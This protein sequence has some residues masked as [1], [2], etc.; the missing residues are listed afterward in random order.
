MQILALEVNSTMC[1]SWHHRLQTVLIAVSVYLIFITFL[2]SVVR[3]TRAHHHHG[4]CC[5]SVAGSVRCVYSEAL[6]ESLGT[7]GLAV[8]SIRAA[9]G[10]W[11]LRGQ[12]LS[13]RVLLDL[14]DMF[15]PRQLMSRNYMWQCEDGMHKPSLQPCGQRLIVAVETSKY[16]CT[17]STSG[18]SACTA[19]ACLQLL[20]VS[21][22]GVVKLPDH[23]REGVDASDTGD[24][25]KDI[26]G[27][28]IKVVALSLGLATPGNAYSY[29]REK[30]ECPIAPRAYM[31]GWLGSPDTSPVSPFLGLRCPSPPLPCPF[32]PRACGG[33][34]PRPSD[35]LLGED[36]G[37]GGVGVGPGG[38][39]GGLAIQ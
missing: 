19:A 10:V 17:S 9:A 28:D 38:G 7:A 6:L 31:G 39:E 15:M 11:L 4:Q 14:I 13:S 24:T 23:Q 18:W 33:L 16:V 35:G 21:V 1:D 2:I 37:G 34:R 32:P 3:S 5:S 8:E 29:I 26:L 36:L 22:C 27:F 12:R 20:P 30:C 25:L